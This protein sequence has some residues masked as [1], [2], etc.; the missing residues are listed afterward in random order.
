MNIQGHTFVA[1]KVLGRLNKEISLGSHISDMVPFVP[2]S[3]FSFAEIHESPD[4]FLKFLEEKYPQKKDIA[5]AMMTHSVKFGADKFNRE[6]DKWLL[7]ENTALLENIAAKICWCSGVTI[8]TAKGGRMHNY[9]WCGVDIHILKN[10]PEFIAQNAKLM[11]EINIDEASQL[12]SECFGKDKN[13]VKG[14]LNYLFSE[15]KLEYLIS[16]DGYAILWKKFLSGLPEKDN[17][18]PDRAVEVFDFIYK[19]FEDRWKEIINNVIKDVS[20]RMRPYTN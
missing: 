13:K 4:R 11:A 1:S 5:L 17:V 10:Y 7:G 2:N 9:L 12:L 3:T 20:T 14:E 16:I 19:Q 8:E 18:I 15:I 6:I